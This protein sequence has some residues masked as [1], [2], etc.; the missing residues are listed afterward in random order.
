MTKTFTLIFNF[1]I[2]SICSFA[3]NFALQ[4]NGV[5]EALTIENTIETTLS[6][7]FTLEAWIIAREWKAQSWQGSIITA[8][9][10]GA[11]GG[12]AFR[13]G[14]D[15]RLSIAVAANNAWNEALSGPVMQRNKWHHVA[16]VIDQGVI[17]LYVDG[18]SVATASFQGLPAA[19]DQ[20]ITIGESTGFPG[21]FF[22]GVIDEVR[23]WSVARSASEIASN[24]STM[25]N[26]D[27]PGL[28]AYL[29]M[30]E[31]TGTSVN[32]L[33]NP[34]IVARTVNMDQSNWVE[35][36]QIVD[37]D[38][39]VSN[40]ANID[41]L[42]MKSRPVKVSVDIQNVGAQM[43]D[44]MDVTLELDGVAL[45]T[46]TVDFSL[47][48]G[49]SDT[50]IFKTPIDLT[51]VQDPQLSV[52]ISHPEDDNLFNNATTKS[53]NSRDGLMVNIFESEQHNF[54]SAGQRQ[55]NTITLPSDLSRYDEIRLRIDINCPSTGCD[56]WDQPANIKINTSQG[57]FELGRYITPFGI[58]C[59]PWYIDVTDFKSVLTGEVTFESYIQV[60]GPSG[61][62]L[63]LDLEFVIDDEDREYT[64][65]SPIHSTDYQVYGDP[66]IS[67]DLEDVDLSVAQNT[68]T[69]HVRMQ[70]SGH[71]QGNTD[72][73]AEFLQRMHQVRINNSVIASHNLWKTDCPANSCSNQFGTWLFSRAGWC[74]GQ[75]VIPAIFNTTQEVS[76]GEEFSF[77]YQ[78]QNYTNLRN[79]GYNGGSHTEPH[80][81]IH[82]FFIENSS[83][84]YRNYS[85]LAVARIAFTSDDKIRVDIEN[86]GTVD[87]NNYEVRLYVDGTLEATQAISS[88]INSGSGSV[89]SFDADLDNLFNSYIIAEVVEVNDENPGDNLLGAI[90]EGVVST[91]ELEA[92]SLISV[93][94]N[95]SRGTITLVTEADH[96]GGT[97]SLYSAEGK[98]IDSNSINDSNT[99]MTIDQKGLYL[100]ETV[101]SKGITSSHR[102]VIH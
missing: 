46:E 48:S 16:A 42:A 14:N 10:G 45:A 35:G 31:G 7:S 5:D 100:L 18:V 73:A 98:L 30:N 92:E 87:L 40:I 22:D 97:W 81:R 29:P 67:Y 94:P 82:S 76:P 9:S 44:N 52:T 80:Y 88:A 60:W 55:L 17:T 95:P 43:L 89:V 53:I 54:A 61:W 49:V 36:F 11:N 12:F 96:I 3:Q 65:L 41:R 101:S 4:F 75:E 99:T 25:Y 19:N 70:V 57:I 68:E 26:G 102:V 33:A 6:N 34:N 39:A 86:D 51:D 23:I 83:T 8:D 93:F 91:Q 59:G 71:G 24:V 21:R 13:C 38:V 50:Y 79:T 90:F 15:G 62:N 78:L 37:F 28:A 32:N 2:L 56:P 58:A 27:E 72:N 77:D 64:R 74:P 63:D 69:S 66:N 85:N 20:T 47:E 1:I 84:S